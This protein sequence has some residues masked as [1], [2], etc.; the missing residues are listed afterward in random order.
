[1]CR[2]WG[3]AERGLGEWRQWMGGER[4]GEEGEGAPLGVWVN[5]LM[6]TSNSSK[7]DI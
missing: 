4:F 5:N 3:G 1:M 7:N 2:E 6:L